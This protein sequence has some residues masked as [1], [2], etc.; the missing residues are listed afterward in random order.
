[1]RCWLDRTGLPPA[2][3]AAAQALLGVGDLASVVAFRGSDRLIR[4]VVSHAGGLGVSPDVLLDA[5]VPFW[6]A[7]RAVAL[8]AGQPLSLTHGVNTCLPYPIKAVALSPQPMVRGQTA[9]LMIETDGV[10]FCHV[11]ALG[12]SEPCYRDGDSRLYVPVGVSAL[13]DPGTYPLDVQLVSGANE[14][15][16]SLTIDVTPGSY[17]YQVIAATPQL[18]PLMDPEVMAAA[19]AYL[20]PW[21]A[22][23]SPQRLWD[24]PL[25]APLQSLPP[26]SADY[27]G[28]RSYG[29]MVDGYHS[30]VDYPAATGLP[31][32]APADGVVVLAETLT[33]RGNA[34][35]LDH[36]GGLVTGYWHLSRID[37]QVGDYV[38]RGQSFAAVGSTG[39]STGSHLHWEVWANGVSVD[40]KQWLRE[41]ATGGVPLSPLPV[42]PPVPVQ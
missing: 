31:V 37:V 1:M 17:G 5:G 30:G 16:F 23:R 21:R 36:G 28:R 26:V 3:V 19:E 27:G 10:A 39:L 8:A 13:V 6:R 25:S 29:G 38:K 35:L 9:F 2:H 11:E 32:L 41:D 12:Q 14:V 34:V 22:I 20:V 15:D 42:S 40:G 4:S 7:P 24:L 33:T 18:A